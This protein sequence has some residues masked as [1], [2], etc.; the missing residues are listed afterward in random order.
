MTFLRYP[1]CSSIKIRKVIVLAK[2]GVWVL[3]N[4]GIKAEQ[5]WVS[6]GSVLLIGMP[7]SWVMC[8]GNFL[9]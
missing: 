4:T 7:I 5:N 1:S 6:T 2:Y 9:P 3:W 8:Q